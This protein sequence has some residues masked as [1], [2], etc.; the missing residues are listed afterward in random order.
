M[1]GVGP[2]DVEQRE[3]AGVLDV[4]AHT[5]L[6]ALAQA[7]QRVGRRI[8]RRR[9]GLA[10]AQA[11]RADELGEQ[12]LLGREVPVEEALGDAGPPADVLDAG[13]R[14]AVGGEQLGGR[15]DELLLALAAV[16]GV[17]AVIARPAR[18]VRCCRPP[19]S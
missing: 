1:A 11:H 10:Q 18:H 15:V 9:L 17:A 12:L 2:L 5:G 3:V 4:E 8:H 6:A 13:R 16:L 7:D 14:V 19:R